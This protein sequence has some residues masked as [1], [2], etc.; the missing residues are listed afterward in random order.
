MVSG[1]ALAVLDGS[2]PEADPTAVEV[3]GTVGDVL[4]IGAAVAAEEAEAAIREQRTSST[5]AA[6]VVAL[7]GPAAASAAAHARRA[8]VTRDARLA[9][10]KRPRWPARGA[11]DVPHASG[12]LGAARLAIRGAGGRRAMTARTLPMPVA[13]VSGASPASRLAKSTAGAGDADP[14]GAAVVALGA[15]ALA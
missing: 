9:L 10:A 4:A 13:R 6:V 7:A 15:P 12:A 8:L 11:G 14:A 1:T 3:R 5:I 2:A